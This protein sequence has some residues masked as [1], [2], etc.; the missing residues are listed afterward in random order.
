LQS[1]FELATA[2]SKKGQKWF[3]NGAQHPNVC[4]IFFA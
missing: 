3:P 1:A 2:F 4:I